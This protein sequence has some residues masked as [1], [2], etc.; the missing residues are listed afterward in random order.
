MVFCTIEG[1][2]PF[3]LQ[4]C[5]IR[6]KG[7]G[8]LAAINPLSIFTDLQKMFVVPK[9]A[10]AHDVM[11]LL[12]RPMGFCVGCVSGV[13]GP[14]QGEESARMMKKVG[15][16]LGGYGGEKT[17]DGF[18]GSVRRVRRLLNVRIRREWGR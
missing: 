8:K 6:T 12:C 10:T 3:G 9:L 11:E 1:A 16:L 15:N 2:T 4:N 5:C 18:A 13:A 17:S 7:E 14:N